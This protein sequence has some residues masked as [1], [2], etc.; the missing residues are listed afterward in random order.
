V[1][2]RFVA[3]ANVL[4]RV[5]AAL[6][7]VALAVLIILITLQVICRRF[8]GA[9]IVFTDEVSGYLLVVV[10]FLGLGYAMQRGDHIQV[11]ILTGRL[12]PP[13]L[14]RLR[15]AWCLVGLAFTGLLTVRLAQLAVD[16]A[17][18]GTFSITSQIPLAPIQAVAPVG[19]GLLFLQIVAQ[20]VEALRARS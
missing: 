2:D 7:S 5:G 8:L 3:A 6:A 13:A 12:S 20:L 16:S 10:T 15:I 9:P 14:R 17:R 1:L 11:A 18:L 4:G 19:C